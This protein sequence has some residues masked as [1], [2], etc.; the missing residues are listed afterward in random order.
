MLTDD[1]TLVIAGERQQVQAF[2]RLIA[3][4]SQ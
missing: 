2:K 3:Q 1:L 4:G